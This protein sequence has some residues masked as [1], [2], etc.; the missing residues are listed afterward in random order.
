MLR[1]DWNI[2]GLADLK[3]HD[4]DCKQG[5]IDNKNKKI[6]L[7]KLIMKVDEEC[8]LKLTKEKKWFL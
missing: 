6:P 2:A 7:Q 8:L 1:C 4:S 3:L 5:N